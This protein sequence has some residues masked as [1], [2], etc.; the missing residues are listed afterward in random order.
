MKKSHQ[1]SALRPTRPV[2]RILPTAMRENR[3]VQEKS[4]YLLQHRNNPV[5]WYPWGEAAFEKARRE[6]KP[7][8]LSVG[9]STCHWCHVMEHES[10]E[11]N[12]TAELL[13]ASFVSI[14]VD[15]EERPDVD[16]V[17]MS[18][19]QASTGQGGWPMSVF[20]TPQLQP[21]F[22]GTYF[23]PQDLWGRPGFSTVLTNLAEAWRSNPEGL[24]TRGREVIA[25]LREH[26]DRKRGSGTQS[27][28]LG[29]GGPAFLE[30]ACEEIGRAFDSEYGGFGG[31]PKFP[32]PVTPGFL[33]HA[34]GRDANSLE[35][36]LFTLRKMA[37][38]GMYDHLGGGFH[39][40]SVDRFWHIPHFE[41]M[42]YDQ[43]QLACVYLDAWQISG[44][45][46]FAS[47]AGEILNYVQR[48]ITAPGGGFYSAEDAD[49]PVPESPHETAEGAFYLW[50]Q[51]EIE[52]LLGD[53]ADL[54]IR[55]YG[56]EAEGN[57]PA[58]SDPQGEFRGKNTLIRRN[59]D[60]E[61]A[62]LVGKTPE[63]V[64][65]SLESSRRM[66]LEVRSRRPRPHLDDKIVTAWNGLMIS[67][68]A[69]GGALPDGA[70]FV[71]AAERAA[72]FIAENLWRDGALLR[73]YREGPGVT[74]GFADD[75]AFLIQGLLDLFEAGKNPRWLQW[76]GQLQEKMDALFW[77]AEGG[78]YFSTTGDDPSVLL[79]TKEEYD[80]AEPSPNSVAALNLLRLGALLDNEALWKRGETVIDTFLVD[81]SQSARAMPAMLTA[82]RFALNGPENAPTVAKACDGGVCR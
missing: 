75:Y 16:R 15:R 58:G 7:I 28:A 42:L 4:P 56:V 33:L 50:T 65:L 41:K 19:V 37:A 10:F 70:Q 57:A 11:N 73:S 12:A 38:G 72:A 67:G 29:A 30:A 63:A 69:R 21:F 22:G 76:A 32:R 9:Y 48:D 55:A 52:R 2:A 44:D 81:P 78:G 24:T 39:R 79:R 25:A 71:E 27:P 18:F 60:E 1:I 45:P 66:L 47:V 62:P 17:Y 20:L 82:C 74:P 46:A 77:D 23:P 3:L 31:A 34:H 61:L 80:G 35:I 54:F 36:A 64:A 53:E 49:S 14:K 43:G 59:T 40:Y 68:F 51:E 6:N 8:F 13:N 5:D 26:L